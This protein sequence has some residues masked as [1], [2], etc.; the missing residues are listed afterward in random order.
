MRFELLGPVRASVDGVPIAIA[1]RHTQALLAALL[2]ERDRVL[3]MDRL[4]DVVWG[5][6]APASVRVQVQN[7][8]AILRRLLRDKDG[9][10]GG[11][12]ETQGSGYR[13]PADRAQLDVDL[14]EHRVREAEW[15]AGTG[16]GPAA[17][18]LLSAA[19]SLWRGSALD[20]LESPAM[21]VAA[22]R[23]NERRTAAQIQWADMEIKLGRAPEVLGEL[24]ELV[25]QHPWHEQL[26]AQL[27]TA[28]Y[29][30]HRQREALQS[31]D[32]L[33]QRLADDLGV[34]PGPELSLLRDRILR[35]D[36]ALA[37]AAP[38]P[39]TALGT[40]AGGATVP[41]QLP[42]DVPVFV[43]RAEHLRQLDA[44][45]SELDKG[46]TTAPIT[47]LEG[48]AGTGKTTLAVHW[49]HRVAEHF[50]DGQLFVNLRGFGSDRHPMSTAEA[51]RGLLES[52]PVPAPRIPVGFDAQLGL[53]RSILA[54]RRA[55]IVLD[56]AHDVDQVRP[57]LPGASRCLTVVTSRNRLF[58]LFAK[59]G[60]QP[61]SLDP[62]SATEAHE[63]FARRVG[64]DRVVAEPEATELIVAGCA[65]L[66]LALAVLA[67]RVV[68]RRGFP[69]ASLA[70]E[71][72][73]AHG[74]LDVFDAGAADTDV[75]AAFSWSY[76][77]LGPE[78]A[79]LFRLLALH[80]GRV[81]AAP[82][83][84]SLAGV[85]VKRA[86]ALLT[87]LDSAHMVMECA[88][89]RFVTHDLLRAYATELTGVHDT[90]AERR[91]AMERM[92]NHYLQTARAEALLFNPRLRRDEW[93]ARA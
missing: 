86:R 60:A 17:A 4:I 53:Y 26:V 70:D 23:L 6:A 83:A 59:E 29:V 85:P 18:E 50:G 2:L 45:L 61:L 34:D 15:H 32:Q 82:A 56:N 80:P 41:R 58:G 54:G 7:R 65:G 19:L 36:P 63:L 49:A 22:R 68:T 24:T 47:V 11:V 8:V 77:A 93:A 9:R 92:R 64:G 21:A 10:A 57:L 84:A 69:L 89:G 40:A 28:L 71:L 46:P 33:R 13:I 44:L 14:F 39:V 42:G 30:S 75:R 72:R 16:A 5:D 73:D 66:P 35:N 51:L 31:F 62:L 67:A 74:R 91:L 12:I 1:G 37:I 38:S 87:E 78:S 48:S 81:I 88:P 20:G 43:G 3:P 76:Q 25:A 52:L 90:E 79:R 27:M 55:L